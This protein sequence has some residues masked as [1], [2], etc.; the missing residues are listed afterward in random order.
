MVDFGRTN[1]SLSAPVT[2]ALRDM[3]VLFRSCPVMATRKKTNGSCTTIMGGQGMLRLP[4]W[5]T[6]QMGMRPNPHHLPIKE[7]EVLVME[8]PAFVED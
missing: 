2:D 6:P 3:Q 8:D 7:D 5:R 4:T 1:E